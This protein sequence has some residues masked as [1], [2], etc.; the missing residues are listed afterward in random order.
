MLITGIHPNCAF[1]C[2]LSSAPFWAS[3]KEQKKALVEHS[4]NVHENTVKPH[5]FSGVYFHLKGWSRLGPTKLSI[6]LGAEGCHRGR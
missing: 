6:A 5:E 2:P 4:R 1:I 3:D